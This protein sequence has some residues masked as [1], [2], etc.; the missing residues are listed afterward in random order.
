MTSFPSWKPPDRQE[1]RLWEMW[2]RD[3]LKSTKHSLK[4]LERSMRMVNT[5]SRYWASS[6]S[7]CWR[8]DTP[9]CVYVCWFTPLFLR[10]DV[11]SAMAPW[12]GKALDRAGCPSSMLISPHPCLAWHPDIVQL[13]CCHSHSEPWG[14]QV[15]GGCAPL[16]RNQGFPGDT[17]QWLL[18]W[19]CFW[20]TRWPRQSHSPSLELDFLV[21]TMKELG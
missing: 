16:P 3:Y 4:K 10:L 6:F 21:S 13:L 19:F 11:K 8:T 12:L 18:F 9:A 5:Y 14:A 7:V 15:G 20:L 1:R 2:P 17:G